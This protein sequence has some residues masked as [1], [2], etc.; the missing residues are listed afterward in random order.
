[1]IEWTPP[2]SRRQRGRPRL[3]TPERAA[4][5]L[6]AISEGATRD[7]AAQAA[8]VHKA[9]FLR[10]MADGDAEVTGLLRDFCD[11][12]READAQ[13]TVRM[14]RVITSA[15][16]GGT[17]SAAAWWLERRRPMDFGRH[18]VVRAE[19]NSA[20]IESAPPGISPRHAL[21]ERLERLLGPDVS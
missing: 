14:C 19:S 4:A 6:Q 18:L 1:M 3:F 16:E 17:W 12:V 10:W 13:V 11:R 7:Q 8:G 2:P 9:T 5:I 21:Q 15:A 20:Q